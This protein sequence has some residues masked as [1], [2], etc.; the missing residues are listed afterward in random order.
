M[1]VNEVENGYQSLHTTIL[2]EENKRVE[3]Q[4]RTHEMHMIAEF[5]SAAEHWRY[6]IDKAYRKGKIPKVTKAKDQ[7]WS[8]ELTQLR[9]ILTFEQGSSIPVQE[10]L[11]KNQ[12]FVVTPKGHI[13]DLR[14]GAT[15]LD[16]AYRVHT[17]LGHRYTGAKVDGLPVR[18]DY[19]LK[20][21][22]II[23]LITSRARTGP[24]SEWLAKSKD[25]EGNATYV[26]ARTRKAREK[27]HRELNKQKPKTQQ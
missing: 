14:T 9:M 23:E 8:Q 10:P 15:P 27:I 4:I 24:S 3:I 25:E 17:D 20:N 5:G 26:F 19:K 2:F 18:I 1:E 6:K 12:I 7:L 22:E 13:I 11:F 21:G 16:F